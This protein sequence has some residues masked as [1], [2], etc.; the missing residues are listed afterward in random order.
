[1]IE[2]QGKNTE[3]LQDILDELVDLRRHADELGAEAIKLYNKQAGDNVRMDN[4]GQGVIVHVSYKLSMDQSHYQLVITEHI[5]KMSS[6]GRPMKG[7]LQRDHIIA[8]EWMT[9]SAA[10]WPAPKERRL[11]ARPAPTHT[12]I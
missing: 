9:R 1:M 11:L 2:N 4:D 10:R 7:R 6:M 8:E 12:E 5:A 3:R